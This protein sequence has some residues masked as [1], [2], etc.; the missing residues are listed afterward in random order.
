MLRSSIRSRFIAE[1]A[2]ALRILCCRRDSVRWPLGQGAREIVRLRYDPTPV[3]A[4][5]PRLLGRYVLGS[6]E[7]GARHAVRLADD[8]NR[9]RGQPVHEAIG[10]DRLEPSTQCHR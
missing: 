8:E 2:V 3:L 1:L 6:D 4:E 10:L 5:D 7:A 9:G